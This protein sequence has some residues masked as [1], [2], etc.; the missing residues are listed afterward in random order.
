MNNSTEA[1]NVL[2]LWRWQDA[3]DAKGYRCSGSVGG[4]MKH[5]KKGDRLF[6]CA[7]RDNEL[8]LLG[9]MTVQ[10]VRRERSKEAAESF[11]SHRADGRCISGP[12]QII[13]LGS[14]KWKLRFVSESDRLSKRFKIASQVQ[15]HRMLSQESAKLL[16]RTLKTG[17][18]RQAKAAEAFQ[19]EGR[20]MQKML[21]VRERNSKVR[22]NAIAKYGR[23]CMICGFDFA[24]VYGDWA[25]DCIEV[26]HLHLVAESPEQGR[27]L[28]LTEVI[29]VC[30]NC[31]R[32]L[33]RCQDPSQWKR[34]KRSLQN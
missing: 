2:V 31:H 24:A 20:L 6:I 8:F 27:K 3:E 7:T 34:L 23:I 32:A 21:T 14:T 30:P 15:A 22:R 1:D 5:R 29:V 12:F 10:G 25:R 33:H 11:G 28:G 4:Q 13:P 26:H 19:R 17:Q 9:A 16:L 18:H